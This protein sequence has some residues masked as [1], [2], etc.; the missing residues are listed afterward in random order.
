[1]LVKM[2]KV[3]GKNLLW[4][5]EVGDDGFRGSPNHQLIF[6]RGWACWAF[7][8]SFVFINSVYACYLPRCIPT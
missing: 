7:F 2:G 1:M 5:F 3:P 6:E 4:D 8:T